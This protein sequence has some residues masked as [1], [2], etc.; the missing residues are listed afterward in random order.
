MERAFPLEI[1]RK[2][3]IPSEVLPF[4]LFLP[5]DRKISASFATARMFVQ[6]ARWTIEPKNAK[7]YPFQGFMKTED[8]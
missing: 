7:I 4:F 5:E 6:R 2:I 8:H 1:F 3:G